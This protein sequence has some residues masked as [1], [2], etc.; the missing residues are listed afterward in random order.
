MRPTL[1][2]LAA[3]CLSSLAAHADT[4]F[5][6]NATLEYGSVSGTLTL[7]ASSTAFSAVDLTYVGINGVYNFTTI[8]SQ[9]FPYTI[10][11]PTIS[12]V[13]SVGS[14]P[15]GRAALELN[16]PL[17]SLVGYEGGSICTA[18]FTSACSTTGGYPYPIGTPSF[19]TGTNLGEGGYDAFTSGTLTP[20]SSVTPEPST[21]ALLG[22]GLLGF[23]GVV[24][25]RFI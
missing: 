20:V 18:T 25:K 11:S 10:Y 22:T 9:Y 13:E 19:I 5:D 1:F 2:A 4:I 6:L 3:L 8:S 17:S 23:A 12:E 16:L 24:R 14:I 21:F 7:N 15:T